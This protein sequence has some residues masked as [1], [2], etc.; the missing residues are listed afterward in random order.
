MTRHPH[1]KPRI[2]RPLNAAELKALRARLAKMTHEDLMKFYDSALETCQFRLEMCK[3]RQ[4]APP[5][6]AFLQQLV[7]AWKEMLR[8][9]NVESK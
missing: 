6:V 5:R 7:Q 9:R 1:T 4:S 2:E 3:L 8:R